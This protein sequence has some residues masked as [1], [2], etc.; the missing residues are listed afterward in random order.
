MKVYLAVPLQTNR[1]KSL[2][3]TLYKI[4]TKLGFEI[5]SDWVTWDDPNPNLEAHGIYQRDFNA[6]QNSDILVAEISLPSMGVGMEIMY[7]HTLGKPVVCISSD[8]KISN[9]VKGLPNVILIHY[10]DMSQLEK[11]LRSKIK[12]AVASDL[13]KL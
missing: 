7:A 12:L 8:D 10:S 11:E 2:S 1:N 3:L 9:M 13:A 6:I 5:V 4:I